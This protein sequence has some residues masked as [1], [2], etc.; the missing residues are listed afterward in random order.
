MPGGHHTGENAKIM[1]RD[2]VLQLCTALPGAVE[3]YPFGEGVAVF[4][5]TRRFHR[6]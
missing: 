4:K 3:D 1:T 5:G 2:D 6:G